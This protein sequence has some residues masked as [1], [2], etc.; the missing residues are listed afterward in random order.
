MKIKRKLILLFLFILVY[1]FLFI[2]QGGDLTDTG[3]HAIHY[4]SFF[5]NLLTYKVDGLPSDSLSFLTNLIGAI[6]IKIFPNAGILGLMILEAVFVMAITLVTYKSLNNY[7]NNKSIL[8]LG[9]FCGVAFSIRHTTLAF[10]YDISSFFFLLVMSFC[11]LKYFQLYKYIY[12]F[13]S[14]ML[15]FLAFTSRFPNIIFLALFPII[16][17][18]Q[19]IHARQNKSFSFLIREFFIQCIVFYSGFIFLFGAFYMILKLNG[20]WHVYIGYFELIGSD[21]NPSYS[22]NR[23]LKGYIKDF[24]EFS[25]HII[26]VTLI[27][28]P[29]SRLF[30][31]AKKHNNKFYFLVPLSLLFVLAF[32]IYGGFSIGNS[33][34]YELKYFAPAFCTFPLLLSIIKKDRFSTAVLI[35]SITGITQVSGTNTG[36]FLKL[37]YGLVVL[38][39]LSLII[40]YEYREFNF[41]KIKIITK[42]VY[43]TGILFILFFSIW[44]R[45]GFIYH[46]DAGLFARIRCTYPIKHKKMRGVYTSQKNAVHINRLTKSIER[47]LKESNTLFI[48]GHQPM[49]YYLT[50]QI[51][52][53]EKFWL[54]DNAIQADNLITVLEKSI[55]KKEKYPLIVDT[56]QNI[57]KSKGQEKL[58]EFLIKHDYY[59]IDDDKNFV[60]W[61]TD[62]NFHSR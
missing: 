23:L 61:Q 11:I 18:Y 57:M 36:I 31:Y 20:I 3:F 54:T 38:I 29:I 14:G 34:A 8:L 46:V 51:P 16:L 48:Y 37:S 30:E 45:V 24:L 19:F 7:T 26:I 1:P 28:F 15:L 47:N 58:N 49:F 32:L 44:S 10:S 21:T 56:K 17:I 9:I 2:W 59:K 13:I 35:F 4:Q 33:S 52:P 62:L 41:K 6:W 27:I 25:P 43:L 53:I 55:L 22:I 39:P 40:L 42:P 12:L 60:I 5:N 50:E